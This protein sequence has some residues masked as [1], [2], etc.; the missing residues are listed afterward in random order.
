MPHIIYIR[1]SIFFEYFK[2]KL[3]KVL[4]FEC[5]EFVFIP[6]HIQLNYSTNEKYFLFVH[7]KHEKYS[8]DVNNIQ[9]HSSIECLHFYITHLLF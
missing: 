5:L 3:L 2:A 7:A 4:A 1:Y 6:C 8:I 9:N